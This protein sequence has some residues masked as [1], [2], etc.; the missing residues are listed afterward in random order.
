MKIAI[1]G[2]GIGGLAAALALQRRGFRVAVYER[3][4]EIREIGAGV[5]ITANARRALQD[6][7]VDEELVARSSVVS[8]FH[9]CYFAT[10]EVLRAA[11]EFERAAGLAANV[12]ERHYLLMQV[13]RLS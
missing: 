5:I 3:A 4:K 1:I 6:L 13:E 9:T 10:G 2:A 8:V 7:G 11:A 12:A